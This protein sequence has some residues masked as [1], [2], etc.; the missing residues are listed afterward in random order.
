M[1]S[2]RVNVLRLACPLILSASRIERLFE[3]LQL[4]MGENHFVWRFWA[5]FKE[6]E[7][8]FEEMQT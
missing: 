8:D 2:G 4:E 3:K 5:E 7:I 1:G 6:V